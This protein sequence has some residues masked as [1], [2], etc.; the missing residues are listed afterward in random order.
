MKSSLIALGSVL[1]LATSA[2]AHPEQ[3]MAKVISKRDAQKPNDVEILNFGKFWRFRAARSTFLRSDADISF[4]SLF[5]ASSSH[6][7]VPRAQLLL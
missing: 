5:D 6:P 2:F 7:R 1:A 4:M 3:G